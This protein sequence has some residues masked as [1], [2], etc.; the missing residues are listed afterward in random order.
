MKHKMASLLFLLTTVL[1]LLGLTSY[2]YMIRCEGQWDGVPLEV[3]RSSELPA[4]EKTL[5]DDVTYMSVILGER[6]PENHEALSRC[7][8]WLQHRWESLGYEVR[9]Q[10]FTMEG[11]EY[12]N[13]EVE[14]PG[15]KAPSQIVIVSAQYDTLP[16]SPGANNNASGMA[17]LLTLSKM[18][19]GYQPQR[20]LRLVAFTTEEPPYFG[21]EQM[22][23]FHYARR[24]RQLEEDIRVMISLD[25][26]GFYRDVPKSQRLPF[27]FSLFYPD[28]ANFLAFI[29]DLRSRR[30]VVEAT[31]GFKQGSAFPIEAGVAP[32]WVKGAS[33]S[34]HSSFWRF[35][36][37]GMQVTDTGA[38]RSP[39]HT[40]Q[41]DTMEKISFS[42]LARI[43]MGLYASIL[44]L[45][46]LER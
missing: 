44:H 14:L 25:A 46:S 26:L 4:I 31:K 28:R 7:A 17:I 5:R 35:G 8:E 37:M 16:G 29:G 43:T 27:P 34:D 30:S 6:N 45:T 20:T 11:A 38:F 23:S 40:N 39:W 42:S 2:W 9:I 19:K 3:L 33:W 18:L 1:V 13:L 12:S 10:T 22:G 41:G 15:R 24:S 21:T 36:Y 32:R